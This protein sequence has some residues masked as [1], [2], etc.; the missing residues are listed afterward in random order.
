VGGDEFVILLR[1]IADG[2]GLKRVTQKLV[3][4]VQMPIET[5]QATVQVGVSVGLAIFP[6]DAT[7]AKAL[8]ALADTGM[9]GNKRE[10]RNGRENDASPGK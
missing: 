3:D 2:E 8:L 7:D 4:E 6:D 5:E 1:D 9:Y 10:R